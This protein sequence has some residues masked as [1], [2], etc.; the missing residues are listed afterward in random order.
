MTRASDET[1]VRE[2]LDAMVGSVRETP[3]GP[4]VHVWKVAGKMFA[5]MSVASPASV[6]LK[7]DPH[8]SE[9][10]RET[11]ASVNPGYH[12]NKRHWNTITFAADCPTPEILRLCAHSYDQVVASLPKKTRTALTGAA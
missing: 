6:S 8:L 10:L 7:A 9:V 11:Y 1:A 5:L 4:D 12:L 2:A 3:F